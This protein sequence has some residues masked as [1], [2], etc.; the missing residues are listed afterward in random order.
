M[1]Y[2]KEVYEIEYTVAGMTSWLKSHGFS[3]I[4]PRPMPAKAN[5]VEQAAFIEEYK[6]L[7]KEIPEGEP[8]LFSD[9]VHPT[10]ATKMVIF[11]ERVDKALQSQMVS[12]FLL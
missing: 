3:F 10:M 5:P 11:G 1:C 2:I 8:M 9:A 7:K 4:K 12:K 6:K